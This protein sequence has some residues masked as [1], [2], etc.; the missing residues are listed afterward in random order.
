MSGLTMAVTAGSRPM[1]AGKDRQLIRFRS[2]ADNVLSLTLLFAYEPA[3]EATRTH[4]VMRHNP[5][6][7][8]VSVA[9]SVP[10]VRGSE[11]SDKGDGWE[12]P[13]HNGVNHSCLWSTYREWWGQVATQAATRSGPSGVKRGEPD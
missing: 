7:E 5:K 12:R 2:W 3:N 6:C 1:T 8:T 10:D 4:R 11:Q 9:C 13:A